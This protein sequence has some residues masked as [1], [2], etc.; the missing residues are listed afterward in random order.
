MG[1]NAEERKKSHAKSEREIRGRKEIRKLPRLIN[2]KIIFQPPSI[3]RAGEVDNVPGEE[4]VR[5]KEKKR[6]RNRKLGY[7]QSTRDQMGA[8][9][10]G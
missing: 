3:W 1:G 4:R 10:E 8:N 9:I 6:K 7:L 5:E 2:G